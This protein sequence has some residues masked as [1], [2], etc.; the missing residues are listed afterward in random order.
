MRV[1]LVLL[2]VGSD[3]KFS[4][5]LKGVKGEHEFC[6]GHKNR[7]ADSRADPPQ[8]WPALIESCRISG[9]YS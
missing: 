5:K 4:I 2:G 6:E 3:G 8:R 7:S 1:N 9:Q